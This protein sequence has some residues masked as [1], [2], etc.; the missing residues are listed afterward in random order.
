MT[1]RC[2]R[3]LAENCREAFK[4]SMNEGH[5][6]MIISLAKSRTEEVYLEHLESILRK[7]REEWATWLDARKDEFV[8][9]T[10]LRRDCQRWG[11]VTSNAVENVNS[12]LLD[13]RQLPI[14]LL[15]LGS[16]DKVQKKYVQGYQRG[17]KWIAE[18]KAVTSYAVSEHKRLLSSATTREVFVTMDEKS[19]YAGKVA[20]GLHSHFNT[21]VSL[22]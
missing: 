13:I 19:Y 9:Y 22:K 4:Y 1:S 7:V 16:V 17:Q 5:K 15:L 20:T 3:H 21:V 14:V 6:N 11:K 18:K 8:S 12:S 10:F 2:A